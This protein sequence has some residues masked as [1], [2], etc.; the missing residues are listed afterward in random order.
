MSKQV[1][2]ASKPA[3][4]PAQVAAQVAAPAPVQAPVQAVAAPAKPAAVVVQPAEP[5]GASLLAVPA[6]GAPVVAARNVLARASS[7][8][9]APPATLQG[10]KLTAGA[11][12]KVR[13][14]YT[15]AAWSQVEAALKK[16]GGAAP[17]AE[18]CA[19]STT[20]FVRYAVRRGWLKVVSA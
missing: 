15:L 1:K 13:V 9:S 3:A 20:D 4:K 19:A 7:L 12:C 8:C 5:G 10:V 2:P 11:P 6:L 17:A 14:P 16:A 18:L